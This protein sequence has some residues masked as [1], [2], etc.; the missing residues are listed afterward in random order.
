MSGRKYYPNNWKKYKDA[1][2]E[3]FH[4]PTVEEFFDWKL[5][6]WELPESIC[7]IIRAEENGR[8]NEY[9]YTRESAAEKKVDKLMAVGATFTYCDNDSVTFMEAKDLDDFIDD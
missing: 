5:G 2:D 8:I 9:T 1:P 7:C 3:V 4:T 6:G